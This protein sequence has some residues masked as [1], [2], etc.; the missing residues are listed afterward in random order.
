MF[1]LL[2]SQE[3]LF[4]IKCQKIAPGPRLQYIINLNFQEIILKY[5]KQI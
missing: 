3:K 5:K 4:Y 2:I 1:L